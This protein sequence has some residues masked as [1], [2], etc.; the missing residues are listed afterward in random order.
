MAQKGVDNLL[1]FVK[2]LINEFGVK[3]VSTKLNIATGTLKRWIQQE[4]VPS[5]YQ[6]HLM[7]LMNIEI[8]YTKYSYKDKD[9]FFTRHDTAEYCFNVFKKTMKELNED[10]T[11]YH[12]IEPSAGSG[13]FL[14]V[15]PKERIIALDIEP[16]GKNITKHDYLEWKP[17]DNKKYIVFG[18]P[19][20]G[21]R[22]H[23]A[24]MFINHSAKFADFVCFI[25]PQLFE[26]DGK[27]VPRKR[28]KGYNLI[29]SEKLDTDF[30]EPSGN[31]VSVNCIFQI[32]SKHHKSEKYEIKPIKDDVIKVYSVSDGGTPSTTRNKKMW[33]KCDIFIPSTCFGASNMKPYDNFDILPRRK[34]YGIVFRKNREENLKKFKETDWSKVAFLSTNSAYNIRVSKIVDVFN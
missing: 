27:G 25:L 13:S 4:K 2:E 23:L 22:G 32:W 19:P 16:F 24:L 10:E 20:F 8:D 28:V 3:Y 18:N 17:T 11:K 6:F 31:S 12:Y 26:S 29:H 15:L 5:L 21:L 33:Y 9:Q 34:G 7:K 1:Y 14:K 30:I